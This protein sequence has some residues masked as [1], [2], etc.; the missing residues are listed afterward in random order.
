MVYG[1]SPEIFLLKC[2]GKKVRYGQRRFSSGEELYVARVISPSKASRGFDA[3]QILMGR[4]E[5]NK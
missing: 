2:A 3:K 4:L 1:R 5:G